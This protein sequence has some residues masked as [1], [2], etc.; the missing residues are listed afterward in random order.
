MIMKTL[1]KYLAIVALALMLSMEAL[2]QDVVMGAPAYTTSEE[3]SR[4]FTLLDL[5]DHS[6]VHEVNGAF[7]ICDV[8]SLIRLMQ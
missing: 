4:T 1:H 8:T 2:A 3:V 7:S 5:L 6:D